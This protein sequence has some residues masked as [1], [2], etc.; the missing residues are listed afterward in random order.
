MLKLKKINPLYCLYGFLIETPLFLGE[1]GAAP[2]GGGSLVVPNPKVDRLNPSRQ[3][4]P[5][6][7]SAARQVIWRYFKCE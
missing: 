3:T 6:E 1:E 4:W 7:C 2:E 5:T